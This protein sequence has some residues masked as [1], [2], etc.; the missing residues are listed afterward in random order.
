MSTGANSQT[1]ESYV[2]VYDTIPE[3]WD[4]AREIL[5]ELLKKISEG[6]N[7]REIGWY[8]DEELLSGKQMFPGVSS[9]DNQ[10]FRSVLRKVVDFSPLA[11]GLNVRPHG[12]TVDANFSLIEL[13]GSATDAVAFTGTPINQP[14]ITYDAV[15]INITSAAVFTRAFAFFEYIQEV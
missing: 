12:V 7:V 15:N 3:D 9:A 2:P 11:V 13:W 5:V 6:T 14:N 8:L 4:E 10:Q 1:F